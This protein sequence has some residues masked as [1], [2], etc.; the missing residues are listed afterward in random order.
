MTLRHEMFINPRSVDYEAASTIA[1]AGF[2][3]VA[4]DYNYHDTKA[5]LES[6]DQLQT[7]HDDSELVAFATYKRLLWQPSN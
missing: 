1:A 7:V 4:D 6:A 2:G 3:R 5:H